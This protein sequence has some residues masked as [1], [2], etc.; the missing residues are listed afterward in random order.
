MPLAFRRK[1]SVLIIFLSFVIFCGS[2]FA[3]PWFQRLILLRISASYTVAGF[4]SFTLD[5]RGPDKPEPDPAFDN[6][7]P[8]RRSGAHYQMPDTCLSASFDPFVDTLRFCGDSIVL[9]A[10]SGYTSYA[11]SDGS[12]GRQLVLRG[13][14]SYW[15][16]VTDANGCHLTD[17][18]YVSLL[19]AEIQQSDT[20]I[21]AGST[22]TLRANSGVAL[23]GFFDGSRHLVMPNPGPTGMSPRTF[24]Y[25]VKTPSTQKMNI[26]SYGDA[27]TGGSLVDLSLNLDLWFGAA[28]GHCS[29]YN[30]GVSFL[31]MS[32][33]MTAAS[34][35]SDDTW[36]HIAYVM[37][38]DGDYSYQNI[39]IYVDG[40]LVTMGANST[41]WCGH[42]WGGWT[43]NTGSSPLYIGKSVPAT[44]PY[45]TLYQGAMDEMGIWDVA[46]DSAQVHRVM[47]QGVT[48][49]RS[50]LRSYYDFDRLIRDSMLTDLVGSN[51]GQIQG[52][53]YVTQLTAGPAAEGRRLSFRWSTGD[54]TPMISVT[55]TATTSYILTVSDGIGSCSDTVTINVCGTTSYYPFQDTLDVCADSVV[56]DAGVGYVSQVWNTGDVSRTFTVR[57]PGLYRVSVTDS[58]GCQYSDESYVRF[59]G[60]NILSSDTLIVL[61]D[62]ARLRTNLVSDTGISWSGGQTTASI[63][64]SP[65]VATKYVVRRTTGTLECRDSVVVSV[66]S[67]KIASVA[68]V[69]GDG[70]ASISYSA[71]T[72]PASS[73]IINYAYSKD[74]G[75]TWTTASPAATFG[76]INI[77]GLNN[78]QTYTIRIRALTAGSPGIPSDPVTVTPVTTPSAP[79]ILSASSASGLVSIVFNPPTSNGGGSVLNYEYSVN[80]A[81]WQTRVPASILSPLSISGLSTSA[82]LQLRIRAVNVAGSGPA[83]NIYDLAPG[84]LIP[85]IDSVKAADRMLRVYFTSPISVSGA[86]IVNYSYSIND[87]AH[88]TTRV[89]ASL[90]SP[91]VIGGLQNGNNYRIRIRAHSSNASSAASAA[92][93]GVP[94]TTPSSPVDIRETPGNGSAILHFRSPENNGGSPIVN[95]AWSLNGGPWIDRTP[96][97]TTTPIVIS[98]L[99]NGTEYR[100]RIRAVNSVGGGLESWSFRVIPMTIPDAPQVVSSS[101]GNRM[102]TIT[103][104]PPSSNGGSPI[105]YYERSLNGSGWSRVPSNAIKPLLLPD[106]LNGIP[107]SIRLRAVNLAG[108]GPASAMVTLT[109]RTIPDAVSN[110][111]VVPADGSALISFNAPRSDGGDAIIRY[112]YS[113]DNG[114]WISTVPQTTS[115]P[116]RLSGLENGRTYRIRLRAVNAAG[117]GPESWT[118][119]LTPLTTP[120]APVIQAITGANESANI[121]Y[122]TPAN[123]GSPIFYHEFSLNGG[124][125]FRRTASLSNPIN[126]PGLTNG[127]AYSVRMRSVNAAGAGAASNA[128]TVTPRR[129]AVRVPAPSPTVVADVDDSDGIVVYPNPVTGLSFHVKVPANISNVLSLVIRDAI[130]SAVYR[131]T[132]PKV[133]HEKLSVDCPRM[134]SPGSYLLELTDPEGVRYVTRFI[135]R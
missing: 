61:G 103:Y 25:W 23:S 18:V 101:T 65:G 75:A 52:P 27:S 55:P 10:G 33:A 66:D 82:T 3:N 93:T 124:A 104:A 46:M 34:P 72:G 76:T 107:V 16:A 85:V 117:G 132:E 95:Y 128:M 48:S 29:S 100:I 5:S 70:S 56:L 121:R 113:L 41:N 81:G 110:V 54:T 133:I 62:S 108:A 116:L 44:N 102:V 28:S 114:P 17:T 88:W 20:T 89:P 86:P 50:G 126:L 106:L 30:M 67:L 109:P 92:V 71:P 59:G 94:A 15:V 80:G 35:V 98:G 97:S 7:E 84:G 119:L 135:V 69:A 19:K 87:G 115:S 37:G 45:T 26:L 60:V 24:A 111:L 64:V 91:I 22:L 96:A 6:H 14:G 73:R 49:I 47:R 123:G 63:M 112:E 125:W 12:T 90:T 99:Q 8:V 32:H 127:V 120:D 9:D 36:H 31:T 53:A 42:N 129:N 122:V 2:V 74:A 68:A 1:A 4:S 131:Q 78:G 57:T 39:K 51:H 134:F 118:F 83:S 13:S 40:R 21:S 11:W 77:S 130:G 105:L 58:Y 79:T 38:M 43:F